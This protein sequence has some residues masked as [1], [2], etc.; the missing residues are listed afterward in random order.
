LD[1]FVVNYCVWDPSKEPPCTAGG[2][3]VYCHPKYYDGLAN[4]LFRNNG[5]RTFTD[6]SAPSGIGSHIGKGMAVNFL[7]YDLDG[8]L[9]AFVTNDTVPNFL[10]RN[11]GGGRFEQ[12]GLVAGVAMN[13]DGRAVSSMGSDARDIDNDG[14]ED[15]FLAAAQNETFPLFRNLG[16]GLFADVTYRSGIGRQTITSTGWSNGV[17]DFNNDGRKDL[18]VACGSID[19]N[20]EA[21]SS[22]RS[23]QRNMVFLNRGDGTFEESGAQAGEDFQEASMHRGVA[24][25]DFDRDGRIDAAVSRIGENA[26]IFRNTTPAQHHWLV[27]RLKGRRSNRD[28]IGAL[29]RVVS[30]SGAEQWNRV[31][32]S[33][34][35]ACSSDRIAHFGLGRE[36]S[37]KLVEIRWPNGTAQRLENVAVDRTF[38]VEEP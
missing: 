37:L 26:R 20:A 6:V 21:F 5:D 31:T 34:G 25:G 27:L 1:L 24:F 10:F 17:F 38:T 22:R 8:R 33:T 35:Y 9:D 18:F 19:D 11:L 2:A 3:R 14:R 4:Q 12:V 7:D 23:R 28:G 13:E 30:A 16:Q 32:T 29:V 15:L 36:Q